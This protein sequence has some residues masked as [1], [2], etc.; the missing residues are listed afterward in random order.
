MVNLFKAFDSIV[1]FLTV[2]KWRKSFWDEKKMNG[3]ENQ[4]KF[5]GHS[6]LF[7]FWF[8]KAKLYF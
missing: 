8:S 3:A 1:D 2:K 7:T 5:I 6:L 4:L